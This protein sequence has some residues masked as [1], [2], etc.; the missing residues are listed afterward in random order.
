MQ[1][2]ALLKQIRRSIT[3]H[4]PSILSGVA[5]TGVVTTAYLAAVATLKARDKIREDEEANGAIAG[6]KERAMH[7]AKLVWPVY[8]PTA[9][10]GAITIGCIVGSNKISARRGAAAQ[11]AFVLSERAY[12]EY[13]ARVIEEI[14]EGKD[15]AIRDE[16]AEKKLTKNPMPSPDVLVIGPGN[17]LCCEL[18]TGR[19]FSSDMETLRRTV[20]DLN[21]HLLRHDRAS[22]ADWY[23]MLG[24]PPTSL[25]DDLGWHSDRILELEFTPILAEDGRT[26]LAFD[27]NYVRPIYEGIYD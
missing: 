4:S 7:T 15:R 8:I 17:Q 13:R 18:Y 26:C 19:Y 22:L 16:L 27:Y 21:A 24:L 10:S 6:K 1:T 3:D 2:K 5:I 23:D 20:N 14:G 11:A 9:A 12:N 25:A